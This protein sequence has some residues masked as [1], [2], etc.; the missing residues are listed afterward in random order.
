MRQIVFCALLLL[1]SAEALDQSRDR[2]T[3]DA[4]SRH[5]HA[6]R[7]HCASHDEWHLHLDANIHERSVPLQRQ[8][9]LF[10]DGYREWL[11]DEVVSTDA[12]ECLFSGSNGEA[13]V[14]VHVHD[15][16]NEQQRVTGIVW[17]PDGVYDIA[18]HESS[19]VH[20]LHQR[21]AKPLHCAHEHLDE[22]DA[23]LFFADSENSLQLQQSSEPLHLTL[24]VVN[25]MTRY[26]QLDD[27]TVRATARE[28]AVAAQL[29]QNEQRFSHS[30]ELRL[31]GQLTMASSLPFDESTDPTTIL[32]LFNSWGANDPRSG[33]YDVRVLLSGRNF[34]G[35][36]VGM[37]ALG[38]VCDTSWNGAVVQ[39]TPERPE[40]SVG[41][42]IAHEVGHLLGMR[43]EGDGNTCTDMIGSE[44]SIMSATVLALGA[45][46]QWSTCSIDAFNSF[47]SIQSQIQCLQ[48]NSQ[49][50][51]SR[52]DNLWE[53]NMA[54]CGDGV[55]QTGE[56]CD[57][58]GIDCDGLGDPCCDGSTC[59]F[60]GGAV[61][62]ASDGCC[63]GTTC[64]LRPA[65]TVC[66]QAE[67]SCDIEE[68][69][70][71]NN[72]ECPDDTFALTGGDCTDSRN[73]DGTC[74][75]G[76][77]VSVN[78]ACRSM[79]ILFEG[80][81]FSQCTSSANTEPVCQRL[82][83]LSSL[84]GACVRFPLDDT[85]TVYAMQVDGVACGTD[86]VCYQN[87]CT[88]TSTVND[89]I[90]DQLAGG[91]P[92]PSPTP[93]NTPGPGPATPPPST[94]W[95]IGQWGS[96]LVT[97]LSQ[98]QQ[99]RV[100]TCLTG[101]CS[102]PAPQSTRAC[103]CTDALTFDTGTVWSTVSVQ[104]PSQHTLCRG[105][106]TVQAHVG[107]ATRE[108]VNM[109]GET[110]PDSACQGSSQSP[111]LCAS[112]CAGSAVYALQLF[113]LSDG[114]MRTGKTVSLALQNISPL[115][116]QT[117]RKLQ[118]E[119]ADSQAQKQQQQDVQQEISDFGDSMTLTVSLAGAVLSS[120]SLS[121]AILV[122]AADSML[123][124]AVTPPL[125][126]PPGR[127]YRLEVTAS[128]ATTWV[129]APLADGCNVLGAGSLNI[130]TL[131]CE[132]PDTMY[133]DVR[134][135]P[136]QWSH[137]SESTRCRS[138]SG[139]K[140]LPLQ[141]TCQCGASRH[142][143]FCATPTECSNTDRCVH[144]TWEGDCAQGQCQCD[145]AWTGERCNQ[146]ALSCV[147]GTPSEDCT[148]CVCTQPDLHRG[149][150]CDR[151]AV[152]IEP[153]WRGTP[154]LLSLVSAASI[155]GSILQ[156]ATHT[157]FGGTTLDVVP[158]WRGDA[159]ALRLSQTPS[160]LD[161]L[162]R[163]DDDGFERLLLLQ[164]DD[165]DEKLKQLLDLLRNGNDPIWR[166][167][168][169]SDLEPGIAAVHADSS[170]GLTNMSTIAKNSSV[171][172]TLVGVALAVFFGLVIW[173]ILRKRRFKTQETLDRIALTN[174]LLEESKS[175]SSFEGNTAAVVNYAR[176]LQ[177]QR[178]YAQLF[179]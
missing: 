102:V 178:D 8:T 51:N 74:H 146:C 2:D 53:E 118:V 156:V 127:N 106:T 131:A 77:C 170:L 143:P 88:L 56:Q 6:V 4:Q 171:E 54:V 130:D 128:D 157:A 50:G 15:C 86:S 147:N 100:V 44:P 151:F 112:T 1:R 65:G 90:A 59:Q 164:Q 145:S 91:T 30:V 64:Q 85:R 117:K 62:S 73:G 37:A 57:C 103:S 67:N 101:Q 32:S 99:S 52:D 139:G 141:R 16:E 133:A 75:L 172:M 10:A 94:G 31:A 60:K 177:R 29:Y 153:I 47:A 129:S 25:D 23:H 96:C 28:V 40:A 49:D 39:A 176:K 111:I 20:R 92:T 9:S 3:S 26:E 132:C 105:S 97:S 35:D 33:S 162:P 158:L 114:A 107:I 22:V 36:A 42:T 58:G 104:C 140:C 134:N 48:A 137:C 124:F 82:T 168:E 13:T 144:G 68:V 70:D 34:E 46:T 179:H 166:S 7:L 12:H 72:A 17:L 121:G 89:L 167:D 108:C 14:A 142:G 95:T 11:D 87:T 84:L 69:C 83:C 150:L 80:G 160:E 126:F 138:A 18:P 63:D 154:N 21:K 71:G 5:L 61:C 161:G 125:S 165:F 115:A 119:L 45:P 173:L 174:R 152:V 24:F 27:E 109:H 78:E 163:E 93:S 55:V 41:A 148:H 122:Q 159:P 98:C 175:R 136:C 19:S 169:L 113:A 66:R 76:T 79:D 149:V 110:Q 81:P 38:R 135:G 123:T 116:F 120:F 43:H 155:I